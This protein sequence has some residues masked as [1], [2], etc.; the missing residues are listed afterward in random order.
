MLNP[1]IVR[2]SSFTSQM[3][4][5][6]FHDFVKEGENISTYAVRF[7]QAKGILN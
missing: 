5:W 7:C 4:L 2:H 6:A 1:F 3:A